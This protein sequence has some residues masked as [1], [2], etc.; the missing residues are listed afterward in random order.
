MNNVALITGSAKR[1]GRSIAFHLARSGWDLALH[2]HLSAD[3]AKGLKAE[4]EEN[5]PKQRFEIFAADLGKSADLERLIPRVVEKFGQPE[6]LINNASVFEPGL[7]QESSADLLQD[8]WRINLF[9]PVILMRD[10]ARQANKGLIINITDTR[11]TKNKSDYFAYTLSKKA[12]WEATKM[13]AL[14]LSP[15]FRVNALA[16]GAILAPEGKDEHYLRAIVEKTPMQSVP[17]TEALMRSL[18]FFLSNETL[19]GQLIFCDG[20]ANLL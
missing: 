19:T 2:Y 13:A 1:I 8:Q 18:D 11:I 14:E 7:L 17:G 16:L 10:F 20:G 6:L 15:H 3:A 5:F 12:L 4:L 9:A